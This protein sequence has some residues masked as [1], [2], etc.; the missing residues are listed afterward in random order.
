MDESFI[1][2]SLAASMVSSSIR[3][4]GF[5][6]SKGTLSVPPTRGCFSPNLRLEPLTFPTKGRG[7]VGF[8]RVK[9]N[10]PKALQG[11]LS[12]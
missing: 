10:A 1:V 12:P 8:T 2:S 9:F 3:R 11:P 6:K 4:E 7:W 5:L